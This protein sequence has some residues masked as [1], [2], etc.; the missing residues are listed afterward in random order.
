M[1]R[2]FPVLR[3]FDLKALPL[4]I[5]AKQPADPVLVVHDQDS[6]LP[7]HGLTSPEILYA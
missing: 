3:L 1:R 5:H 4:Q 2:A 7:V 6:L